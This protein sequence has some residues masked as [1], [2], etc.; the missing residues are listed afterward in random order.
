MSGVGF[1]CVFLRSAIIAF[2][3]LLLEL[4]E[5][6]LFRL[7]LLELELLELDDELLLELLLEDDKSSIAIMLSLSP[8]LGP[9]N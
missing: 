2:Y 6:E 7:L 4:L 5:L 9:G 1:V 8:V 3:E